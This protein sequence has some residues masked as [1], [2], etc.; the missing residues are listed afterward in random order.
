MSDYSEVTSILLTRL[1]YTLKNIE[2]E[3]KIL[4]FYNDVNS[5][6]KIQITKKGFR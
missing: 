1:T 5:K 2:I 6:V 3:I 4:H